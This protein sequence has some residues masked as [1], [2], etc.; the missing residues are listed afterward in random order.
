MFGFH[1]TMHVKV[2]YLLTFL[3]GVSHVEGYGQS[4][5]VVIIEPSDGVIKEGE[6]FTLKCLYKSKFVKANW[7]KNSY[8]EDKVSGIAVSETGGFYQCQRDD[9]WRYHTRSERLEVV[10]IASDETLTVQF[11]SRPLLLGETSVLKC[12]RY[13]WASERDPTFFWYRNNSLIEGKHEPEYTIAKARFS[14]GANYRCERKVGFRKWISRDVSIIVRDFCSEPM[15][16]ADPK[17]EAF[18]GEHFKLVCLAEPFQDDHPLLYTFYKNGESLNFPS[19]KSSY[20]TEEATLHHSGTYQCEVMISDSKLRKKSNIIPFSIKRIPVSVPGLSAHPGHKVVEGD[21]TS[22]NCSVTSG[23]TPIQY[24]FYIEDEEISWEYSN[25]S[26]TVHTIINI[27]ETQ[28]G[29]YRCAVS[30]Q[31]GR[32]LQYSKFIAISVIIPVAGVTLTNRANKTEIL[33]GSRLVLE[34]ELSRGTGPSFQ[35]Y[36]QQ[37]AFNNASGNYNFS[38]DRS[39]LAIESFQSQHQGRYQCGAINRAP[40][41]AIFNVTSNF[42]DL[43]VP[44]QAHS[45]EMAVL[46]VPLF[47][48]LSLLILLPIKLRNRKQADSSSSSQ[49]HR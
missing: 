26:R 43:T 40:G 11:R 31:E 39:E 4:P 6:W 42:I 30:N 14:D 9:W 33:I 44:A 25:H 29:N 19:E 5:K 24:I 10:T 13:P 38:S 12:S 7:Y 47:L 36:F 35:W 8:Y 48:I 2:F 45:A 23:S 18:V 46:I 1:T 16:Q 27:S 32:S 41:G 3:R 34:C 22:L 49:Q 37:E 17:A 20:T 15:L 28:E 21:S